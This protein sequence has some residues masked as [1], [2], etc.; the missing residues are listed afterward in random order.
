MWKAQQLKELIEISKCAKLN[1]SQET[2]GRSK[3]FVTAVTCNCRSQVRQ[4]ETSGSGENRWSVDGTV[5]CIRR[6]NMRQLDEVEK[7]PQVLP[8]IGLGLSQIGRC[9]WKASV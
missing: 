8:R 2:A 4:R 5:P 6:S 7:V 3:Q 1:I 9:K